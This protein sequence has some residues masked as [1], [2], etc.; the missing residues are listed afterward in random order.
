MQAAATVMRA[1]RSI[2]SS[3]RTVMVTIHQPSIEI[4]EAFDQLMLL[5]KGGYTIYFGQIGEEST[6]LVFFCC[7]LRS[8]LFG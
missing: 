1:V 6:D 5:Q 3:G 2:G 7:F 4:F 8:P